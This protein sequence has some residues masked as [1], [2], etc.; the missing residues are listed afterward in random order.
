MEGMVM[1]ILDDSWSKWSRPNACA[2]AEV[3]DADADDHDDG[4]D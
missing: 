2:D 1:R 4:D 3:D